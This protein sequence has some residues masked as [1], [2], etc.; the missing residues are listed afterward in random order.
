[1]YNLAECQDTAGNEFAD[2]LARK[3]T[4]L[5]LIGPE[6]ACGTSKLTVYS[7]I[8]KW[9]RKGHY[10]RWY[11]YS[12]QILAKRLLKARNTQLTGKVMSL[13]RGYF[14]QVTALITGQNH[15]RKHFG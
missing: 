1:M 9:S 5:F 4:L 2:K 14:E 8:T 7:A 3:G 13:N 6:Y 12:G 15:F 11:K 10:R